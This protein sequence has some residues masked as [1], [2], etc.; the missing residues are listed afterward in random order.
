M[1]TNIEFSLKDVTAQMIKT[2]R[3]ATRAGTIDCRDA[4]IESHGDTDKAIEI[5]K[6]KGI[7]TPKKV[8]V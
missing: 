4:I 7:G 6:Q 3:S 1:S 8:W 2:V 5:L